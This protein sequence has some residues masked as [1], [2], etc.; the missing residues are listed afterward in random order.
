MSRSI[1]RRLASLMCTAMLASAFP[2]AAADLT[3]AEKVD[4]L[5]SAYPETLVKAE[6]IHWFS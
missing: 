4:M 2:L 6:G 3:L 5:I 1:D